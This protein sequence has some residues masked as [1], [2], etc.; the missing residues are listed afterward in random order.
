MTCGPPEHEE[1][2]KN[3]TMK[4]KP[5][6]KAEG[7]AEKETTPTEKRQSSLPENKTSSKRELEKYNNDESLDRKW[8]K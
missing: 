6:R 4:N 2:K 8:R 5:D 3:Y 1:E 7:T